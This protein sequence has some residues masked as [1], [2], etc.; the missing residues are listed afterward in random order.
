MAAVFDIE[1]ESSG[2]PRR[3]DDRSHP[4][5][6]NV[7]AEMLF[8]GMIILPLGLLFAVMEITLTG[9]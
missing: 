9:G 2:G 6:Y 8:M 1:I 4:Q 7:F 5:R 3:V